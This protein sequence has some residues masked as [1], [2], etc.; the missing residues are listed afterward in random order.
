MILD[1]IVENKRREVERRKKGVPEAELRKRL[2]ERTA[3]A[4]FRRVISR[5]QGRVKLICE[6][7]KAS[8]S[9]GVMKEDFDPVDIARGYERG[10]ADALSVLTEEK[11]FLGKL[12]HIEAI[13]RSRIV[14][15]ILRKDFICDVYQVLEAAAFGADAVL[16]I[17]GVM[18]RVE[19]IKAMR[20]CE[21]YGLAAVVEVHT[22]EQV[23]EAADIGA[24]IIE[25]NNRDLRTFKVDLATT[26]RLLPLIPRGTVVVIASG[27]KGPEE[28]RLLRGLG[29]DALLVGET[30]MRHPDPAA[31]VRE[32]AEAAR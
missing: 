17:V 18:P 13:K 11:Y 5:D 31:A 19:I 8:P 16:L 27:V 22:E 20:A 24:R 32:L 3:F 30:L 21:E 25:I 15:P 23:K 1:E 10:G 29:V 9:A 2:E 26:E 7:K 6:V 4:D 14:L 28:V 12:E